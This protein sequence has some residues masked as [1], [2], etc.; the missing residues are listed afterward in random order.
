ECSSDLVYKAQATVYVGTPY[1]AGGN[2]ALQSLSTNPDTVSRIA[3]GEKTI[4]DVS[5]ASG[6]SVRELRA[7][8]STSAVKSGLPKTVP[9]QLYI[10]SV[11]GSRRAQ[12]K[13][14]TAGIA[15][16]IVTAVA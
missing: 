12:V 11:K 10:V 3:R 16:R 4:N 13:D 1:G 5:T 14:A 6:M 8:I 15:Q 2:V 9:N 7:G